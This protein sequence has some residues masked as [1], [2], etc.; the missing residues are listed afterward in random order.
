[1]EA[2]VERGAWHS[3]NTYMQGLGHAQL[4]GQQVSTRYTM[5]VSSFFE[6]PI[7]AQPNVDIIRSQ[8][9][10]WMGL[11][12]IKIQSR[13]SL[14]SVIHLCKRIRNKSRISMV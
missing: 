5:Q 9:L 11:L 6:E 10:T 2:H 13:P 14:A 12:E 1:M 4:L 8:S 7:L 3:I